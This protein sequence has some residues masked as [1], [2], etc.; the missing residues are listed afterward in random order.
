[1][2]GGCDVSAEPEDAHQS[3]RSGRVW[4][5]VAGVAAV[6]TLIACFQWWKYQAA[7]RAAAQAYRF[8]HVEIVL[9][10]PPFNGISTQIEGD[11]WLPD[12]PK[13]IVKDPESIALYDTITLKLQPLPTGPDCS[14]SNIHAYDVQV[15]APGF[16]VDTIGGTL[17]SRTMLVAPACSLASKAPPAPEPW[18]WNLM[19]TEPGN[20]VVTLLLLA[21]DKNQDVIDSREVDVPVFVPNPPEPLTA[22][23]G[24]ISI[25]V[26]IVTGIIGLWERFRPKPA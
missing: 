3:A 9:T 10:Q 1:V 16:T 24:F 23:I 19:A 5:I 26:T 18:R 21:M 8:N 7:L 11:K 17:R 2:F 12:G 20:H 25:L 6:I 4:F 13:D 22:Y 14:A 15:D